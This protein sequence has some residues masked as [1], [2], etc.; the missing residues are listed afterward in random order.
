[1]SH[2][3][4]F[5]DRGDRFDPDAN[6]ADRMPVEQLLARIITLNRGLRDFWSSAEGWSPAEPAGAL[7]SRL[8][9]QVSLS[10]A[11]RMWF[12]GEKGELTDGQL[13]LAW[14]NLGALIEGTMRMFLALSY[15]DP[16][17]DVSTFRERSTRLID[18]D[19]NLER[20]R[21]FFL[22][23]ELW[24][25]EWDAYVK[26]VQSRRNAMHAFQARDLGD[27]RE[28]EQAVRG[29]LKLLRE[30]NAELPYPDGRSMPQERD[31]RS[32]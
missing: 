13:I 16:T 1:M 23:R 27:A 4:R 11:L 6:D 21:R 24:S 25:S 8:A 26:Q 10:E 9:W 22:M 19:L 3:M 15:A 32:S 20:L 30:I 7:A 12:P 5:R 14:A 17:Q 31:P 18:A 2:A 28:F 29:Y